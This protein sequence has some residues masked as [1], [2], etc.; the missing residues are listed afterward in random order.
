MLHKI[1]STPSLASPHSSCPPSPLINHL[2][3]RSL[4][5][6][7][8]TRIPALPRLTCSPGLHRGA[9]P[10]PSPQN[11]HPL[12]A[13]LCS[14]S[15]KPSVCIAATFLMALCPACRCSLNRE[16]SFRLP[17]LHCAQRCPQL[18]NSTPCD[19]YVTMRRRICPYLAVC[20]TYAPCSCPRLLSDRGCFVRERLAKSCF[21]LLRPKGRGMYMLHRATETNKK[22][23]SLSE[24]KHVFYAINDVIFSRSAV[25]SFPLEPGVKQAANAR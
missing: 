25:A 8:S 18:S 21:C 12:N 16:T 1:S 17:L 2:A 24:K 15:C 13:A 19:L 10:N 22:A 20:V 4:P 9:V 23:P 14:T 6:C 7:C 11:H 3:L 5:L